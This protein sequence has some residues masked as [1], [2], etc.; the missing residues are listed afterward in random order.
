MGIK[1]IKPVPSLFT[2]NTKDHRLKELSG[3]AFEHVSLQITDTKLKSEGPMLITHWGL[4]GPAILKLSAWGAVQL[5]ALNY[6]F[7]LNVQFVDEDFD[8]VVK[9]LNEYKMAHPKRSIAGNPQFNIPK[10]YWSN[11]CLYLKIPETLIWADA[12]KHQII[13]LAQ[14]WTSAKFNIAGKST[15]KDEFVAAGGVA[16]VEIEFKS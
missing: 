1:S 2:F 15:H 7:E 12:N 10:R 11:V 6:K 9:L 4:S 13:A 8:T 5:A 16:W 14:E 3:V